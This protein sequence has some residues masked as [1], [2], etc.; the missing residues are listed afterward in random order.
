MTPPSPLILHHYPNSPFSEKVRLMLGHKNLPWQS[1]IIPMLSPKPDLVALTGGYR[2]TPVLQ[3]GADIYCDTALIAEVLEHLQPLPT[4]YPAPSRGLARILAQWADTTLFETVMA[5]NL[6][7][8]GL[9]QLFS[10]VPPEA[11]QAFIADRRAMSAG[12]ARQRPQDAAAAY[13]SCL[14]RLSDMLNDRPFMLGELACIA[15]FAMYPALWFTRTR[16]S[17]LAD[18]LSATPAVVDW[19]D[20]MAALG[21]GAMEKFSAREAIEVAAASAPAS[22]HGEMFQDEHGIAL[23]SQV[24]VSAESFGREPTQGELVAATRVRYTLRRLD[25]RA[26]TVHVH[27]PRMGYTLQAVAAP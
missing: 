17:V 19:M 2:K 13:K 20:R 10:H 21:H 6:Q 11:A 4:L 22:L 7:P 15:D 23:G 25:A 27:F 12:M 18:I 1:V 16:T 5:F 14:R 8:K 24:Q 26:G 9:E 3:I